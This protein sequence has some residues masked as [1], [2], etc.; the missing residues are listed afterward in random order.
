LAAREKPLKIRL[1]YFR[2]FS[3]TTEKLVIAI[4][5]GQEKAT[6]TNARY[7]QHLFPSRRKYRNCQN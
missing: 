1:H 4:F 5:D 6:E 7:L 2:D 3:L